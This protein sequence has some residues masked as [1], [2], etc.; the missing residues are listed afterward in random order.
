MEILEGH[1]VKVCGD[2]YAVKGVLHPPRKVVAIP[3]YVRK[4]NG[5]YHRIRNLKEAFSYIEEKKPSYLEYL[6]FT[7]Q[8]TP[9][10]PLNNV[11]EVYDP[12]K[13]DRADTEASRDALMLK[14]IL[15][16]SSSKIK[17]GI[18]GSI[19]LGLDEPSSDIDLV[20]YGVNSGERFI[21]ILK[22]LRINNVVKP[23]NTVDWLIETR[24]DSNISPE[25]WLR[26]ES[27]KLLTGVFNNRLYTSKIVPFPREYWEDLSQRVREIGRARMLCRV[28]D[29]RFGKTTPNLYLVEVLKIMYGDGKARDVSQVMSMRSRF[30]E[31]ASNGDIVEV[32]G[33]LE[34]VCCRDKKIYRIFLGNDERDKFLPVY[35]Y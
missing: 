19:L 15:T 9:L 27:R 10:I 23:V 16:S 25:D 8:K 35:R 14:E 22:D 13:F 7:G 2:I 28:V 5:R 30:A 34:E 11:D 1:Y 32:E 33:R 26:L 21:D 6:N 31:I 12:V 18:T 20:V 3:T 4:E 17:I 29:S 24:R